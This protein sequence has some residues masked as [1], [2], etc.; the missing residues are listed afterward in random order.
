MPTN[1]NHIFKAISLVNQGKSYPA[2][3]LI[4]SNPELA[5]VVSKLVSP[6]QRPT[7]GKDGKREIPGPNTTE[8]RTIVNTRARAINDAQTVMQLLPDMELAAQILISSILSPKDMMTGDLIFTAPEGVVNAQTS[9]ALL[10]ILRAHF[11][12]VYKIKQEL[13]KI[14]RNVL[15]ERGSHVMVVLPENSLDEVINR[16]FN[17]T[18][19]DISSLA[20][21]NGKLYSLGILG[22]REK[23]QQKSTTF[24]GIAMENFQEYSFGKNHSTNVVIAGEAGNI[25]LENLIVTDNVDTLKF[26]LVAEKIRTQ[27]VSQAIGRFNGVRAALESSKVAYEQQQK[28][29]SIPGFSDMH[30]TQLLYKGRS[31]G[32][33]PI[34]SVKTDALLSRK[35]I[36]MPLV[37]Q[38]PSE[39]VIPVHM[40]GHTDHHIGYFV[41]LDANG[42]PV[43]KDTNKDYY[44]ELSER[45]GTNSSGSYTTQLMQRIKNSMQGFD[46]QNR[47]H[48]DYSAR[49]YAEMVEQDLLTRLRNGVYTNGAALAK[50]EE[51]YR[52]MF[53]RVLAGQQTQLLFIPVELVT[54]FAF[55]YNDDGTGKSLLEDMK[56]LNSLRAITMFSNVMASIRNSIGRTDVHLKLDEDDPDP[57]K[58][59]EIIQNEFV[60]S[61][62]QAF[63]L[64]ANS[65][66]DM[67]NYLQRAAFEFSYEGHPGLPDVKLDIAEKGSSNIKPDQELEDSLRKRGLQG[68]GLNP[69][70]VD[71]SNGVEFAT[72][73]V[74]NNILL[75]RR[76][77]QIQ[78]L[79]TPLLMDHLRKVINATPSLIESLREVINENFENNQDRLTEE[80][81][82]MFE[83]PGARDYAINQLLY[84]FIN[85]LEVQLP[86]PN[87]VTL[88]NQ[89]AALETY[90]KLL[91]TVL[92]AWISDQFFTTEVGG[93][94]ATNVQVIRQV[95]R[96]YYIRTWM[97][98]NG[99]LPELSAITA[100]DDEG[101][102]QVDF[103]AA[104]ASHIEGLT[105][106]LTKFM[107]AV[108]KP[109]A[110]SDATLKA[111][112]VEEGAG[113]T[114]GFGGGSDYGSGG[115]TSLDTGMSDDLGL[116]DLG[117]DTSTGDTGEVDQT[118][119]G[120]E[121]TPEGQDNQQSLTGK[122]EELD[123][124]TT[125]ML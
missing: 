93:E 2:L 101:K 43:S 54:Y 97:A 17:I 25:T 95:V 18:M 117:S 118:T 111:N 98:E 112:G 115:D 35:A 15:F 56:M 5:A 69:E 100:A 11:E 123:D 6:I 102:P 108:Q 21:K 66:V 106:S 24:G 89:A 52:I 8:F 71:A 86:R 68:L 26:P 39:S 16:N 41:M 114:G 1:N 120:N 50:N 46:C 59:L 31:H 103:W 94:V 70:M 36:G 72:S 84:D 61:R 107:V 122:A 48:I 28:K 20:D 121:Q 47:D 27:R 60:R 45:M 49:V 32:Y 79:F 78:D 77:M 83:G 113:S 90:T 87:T 14:L 116:G 75:S 13:G 42:N 80:Q 85:G 76:V 62:Q 7:Q 51:I 105:R 10:T 67:V 88:E 12:Q 23:D 19:E 33:T 22:P 44:Q 38:F 124:D 96:S 9:S 58:S 73:I 53:A 34:V 119:Q 37:M 64:G 82:K 99:V 29:E 74:N 81:K 109:K 55:K 65:P 4:G 57:R 40:P 3:D 91:D 125:P 92:D 104:Q 63:P 30:L 110:E